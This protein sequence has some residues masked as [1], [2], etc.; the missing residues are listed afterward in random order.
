MKCL[1]RHITK[2]KDNVSKVTG[3]TRAIITNPDTRERNIFYCHPSYQGREWYD[4]ALV[5]FVESDGNNSYIEKMYPSKIL[6]FINI[7]GKDDAVIQCANKHL[8]WDDLIKHFIIPVTIG[9]QFDVSFVVVPIESIV[10][11]LCSIPVDEEN[12]NRFLVVLP[13][14]NWSAY[15]GKHI[16][17]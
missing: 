16:K 15:F 9:C 8:C 5:Q 6:G 11:P 1:H 7:N 10:H 4:W 14:R 17:V 12:N 2:C 13:K 3:Y